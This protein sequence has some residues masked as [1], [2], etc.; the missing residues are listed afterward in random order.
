MH[1]KFLRQSAGKVSAVAFLEAH[2]E[3]LMGIPEAA[4]VLAQLQL[5]QI[6]PTPALQ[7]VQKAVFEDMLV[8]T[9]TPKKGGGGGGGGRKAAPKLLQACIYDDKNVLQHE[10]GFDMH[11]EADRWVN[12]RLDVGGPRWYAIISDGKNKTRIERD[13]AITK[14]AP[15]LAIPATK[16]TGSN[17]NWKK[18]KAAPTK[19]NFSHG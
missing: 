8:Q 14:L 17:A 11:R 3:F 7:A 1:N 2:Q 5:G 10:A 12:R 13:D 15:R 18:M 6:Y 4:K 16:K 9:S 19:V